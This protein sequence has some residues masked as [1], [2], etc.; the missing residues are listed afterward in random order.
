MSLRAVRRCATFAASLR[1]SS[2]SCRDTGFGKGWRISHEC[3]SH[4]AMPWR[5]AAA[6]SR[7][8]YPNWIACNLSEI[9]EFDEFAET[10][11]RH[12]ISVRPFERCDN[13]ISSRNGR[14]ALQVWGRTR[15]LML[16]NSLDV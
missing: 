8:N 14:G 4:H 11:C 13:S 10:S 9:H 5:V 16:R 12:E 3:L 15:S 7:R 6:A 2:I 1:R